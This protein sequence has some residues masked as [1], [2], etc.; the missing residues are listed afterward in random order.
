M[1]NKQESMGE[2]VV[3]IA[4]DVQPALW[5]R[6]EQVARIIDPSAFMDGWECSHDDSKRLLESRLKY[7]QAIAMQRAQEILHYLGVNTDADWMEILSR[8]AKDFS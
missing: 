2:Q 8:I 7:K 5:E 1:S 4:K 6:T 3:R